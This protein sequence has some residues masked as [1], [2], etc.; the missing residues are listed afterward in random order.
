MMARTKL[1]ARNSYKQRKEQFRR[2][3]QRRPNPKRPRTGF[4]KID[5]R[6]R[7]RDIKTNSLFLNLK[8]CRLKRTGTSSD[9]WL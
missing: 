2:V 7:N 3:S 4:K 8:M 5:G 6:I 1:V 9:G